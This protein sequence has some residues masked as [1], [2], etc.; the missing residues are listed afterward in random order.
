MAYKILRFSKLV[1]E[2]NISIER[3]LVPIAHTERQCGQGKEHHILSQS[4]KEEPGLTGCEA[5]VL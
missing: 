4:G 5:W 2:R 3:G 1:G